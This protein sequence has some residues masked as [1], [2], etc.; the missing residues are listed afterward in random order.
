MIDDEK[1]RH[2]ERWIRLLPVRW[3]LG[4]F[5]L[6]MSW[7][8]LSLAPPGS[9]SPPSGGHAAAFMRLFLQ[10]I[11]PISV[12]GLIWGWTERIHFQRA[13]AAGPAVFE[14]SVNRTVLRD[15]GKAAAAGAVF[16]LFTNSLAATRKFKAWTSAE[17][18]LDNIAGVVVFAIV[19]VPVGLLV[20]LAT[21][22][23]V[24]KRLRDPQ[25][26]AS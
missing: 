18:V 14:R 7:I 4:A 24:R 5:L 13:L 17:D 20:A 3:A 21:R 19:A 2:P 8:V 22:R 10:V 9:R 25:R 11:L 15:L 12:L 26:L 23:N 6:A 1:R 16:G